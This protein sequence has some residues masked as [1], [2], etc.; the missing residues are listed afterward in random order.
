MSWFTRE[1]PG[2]RVPLDEQLRILRSC[3]VDLATG[4]DATALT[5]S[6][7]PA[8][9][10][11]DP[12]RLALTMMGNEAEHAGQGGLSGFLSDDIW[13]FDTECIEGDGSY[14]TI[15]ARLVTLAKG[16]FPLESIQDHVDIEGGNAW[17]GFRLDGKSH[18]LEAEVQ[19][20]WVDT[21]VL[22]RLAALLRERSGDGRRFTYIDLGGQ[23]CLIGCAT[24][25][26]KAQMQKQTGLDVGWL[27]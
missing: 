6:M 15:A 16:D 24:P 14:A 4:V 8:Q 5:S 11:A 19:D 26:Q 23:D 9:F 12:F 22:S 1:K 10:E 13:H 17:L 7:E 25:D 3:G 21:T 27:D 20:D 18:R 2:K